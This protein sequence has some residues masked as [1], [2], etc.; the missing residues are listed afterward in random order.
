MDTG[1]DAHRAAEPAGVDAEGGWWQSVDIA[2][3]A[4]LAAAK[5]EAHTGRVVAV[6]RRVI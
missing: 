5:A 3:A 4:E 6:E 2:V 1:A